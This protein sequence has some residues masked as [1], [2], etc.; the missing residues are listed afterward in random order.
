[1]NCLRSGSVLLLVMCASMTEAETFSGLWGRAGEQWDP[2][3]RLPDFSR[4]GYHN[5]ERPLPNVPVVANV[6][7]F[8]AVGDGVTDDTAAFALALEEMDEGALLIPSGRY[9]ITGTLRIQRRGVVLK[10]EGPDKTVLY[11]PKSLQ[12]LLPLDGFTAQGV[13]KLKYSFGGAF[14]E[15][16]GRDGLVR[17]GDVIEEATRGESSLVCD[18]G[19]GVA[20]DDWVMLVQK[21]NPEMGRHL[22]G[23]Q[24]AGKDTL[25]RP[26]SIEWVARVT[27]VEGNRVML[28]RPLRI[29][30][31]PEWNAVLHHYRPT[32]D[33]VGV[34][35][36]TFEFE[37]VPKKKHLLEEGYNAIQF[38]D[39]MNSWVRDVRF[40][41]ADMG[42]KVGG[43]KFFQGEGL[44][45]VE[46]KREGL[47]GHHAIWA[48]GNSQECLFQDFRVETTYVHDLT[49]ESFAHGNVFR[50]G[51]GRSVNLD[52]HRNGPYEN[53]FSNLDV[54]NPKRL[55]R[56]SG[57]G[58]R[59]P[60]SGARTTAWNLTHSG[61]EVDYPN[62]PARMF[63]QLNIVGVSGYETSTG[64]DK[65]PWIESLQGLRPADLYEA[66]LQLR[67]KAK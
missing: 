8:G 11:V 61:G 1:M 37:G 54:G 35:H 34:E 56:S 18:V 10:G 57:R 67:L 21:L 7:D 20:R 4:A 6:R 40:I 38:G 47:T 17:I 46:A 51:S 23:G 16:R 26:R 13:P 53:L 52:H 22:H 49:V 59:G 27:G 44:E 41:D 66:Q 42:L 28:D 64:D 24:D 48:V 33:E 62:S 2:R 36:L 30:A 19:G 9:K 39:V 50:N 65:G 43:A 3:S 29:D 55:W 12:Q 5:G 31:R 25:S 14:I 32:V 60:H 63:P 58:D 45:F 15:V